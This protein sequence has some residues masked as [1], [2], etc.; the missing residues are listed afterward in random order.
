MMLPSAARG[1]LVSRLTGAAF[2]VAAT[3][4]VIR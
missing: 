1:V 2:L 4:E 3:I